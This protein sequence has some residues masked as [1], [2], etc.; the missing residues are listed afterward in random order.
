MLPGQV[1]EGKHEPLISREL[2]LMQFIKSGRKIELRVLFK[3]KIM[4]ICP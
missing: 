2:F 4:K 3:I 1:I